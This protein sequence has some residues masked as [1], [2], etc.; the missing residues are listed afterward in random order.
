MKFVI[1]CIV[2]FIIIKLCDRYDKRELARKEEIRK[3]PTFVETLNKIN[4]NY[5]KD[6]DQTS[7]YSGHNNAVKT[8]LNVNS[9]DCSKDEQDKQ[10]EEKNEDIIAPNSIL[11]NSKTGEMNVPSQ[12]FNSEKFVSQKEFHLVQKN[13]KEKRKEPIVSKKD[14]K[15]ENKSKIAKL[16]DE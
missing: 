10:A 13:D 11:I 4:P 2:L 3:G 9:V 15:E 6:V 16:F 14:W 8:Y 1:G 5:H 12:Q 7:N